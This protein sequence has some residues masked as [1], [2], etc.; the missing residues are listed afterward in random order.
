M[1]KAYDTATLVKNKEKLLADFE[2]DFADGASLLS[3]F[4]SPQLVLSAVSACVS[5]PNKLVKRGVLD[6]LIGCFE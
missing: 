3:N 5:D 4:P 6:C 1:K 2:K